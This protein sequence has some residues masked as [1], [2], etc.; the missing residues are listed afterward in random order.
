MFAYS[1]GLG[2]VIYFFLLMQQMPKVDTE[3]EAT[4]SGLY[5]LSVAVFSGLCIAGGAI[6]QALAS[7]SASDKGKP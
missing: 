3:I 5:V 2:G 4:F 6:S 1:L 7:R